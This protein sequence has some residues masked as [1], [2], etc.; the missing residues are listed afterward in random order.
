MSARAAELAGLLDRAPPGIG[1]LSLD[2]FD[3]LVWRNVQA[4]IDIFADLPIPGGGIWSRTQA[5]ILARRHALAAEGRHEV[6]LREIYRNLHPFAADGEIDAAI[7]RELEAEARHCYA[8]AP[9]VELIRDAQRRGLEVIV[10]SDTYLDADQLRALIASA[11]G[12][13]IAAMVGRIFCSSAY[14]VPKSLG[15]FERILPELPVPA[16]AILH[17]GDNKAADQDAP[18]R[19]GINAVHFI[20]FDAAAEQRLRMEAAAATMLQPRVRRTSPAFQP[21]RPMVSL[22]DHDDRTWA[23]GHNVLGPILHGFCRWLGDEIDADSARLGRA[24]KPLFL[25]RDGHLPHR[26]FEALGGAA[27]AVEISRFTARRAGFLRAQ[28]IRDYLCVQEDSVTAE[29]M[30]GQLGIPRHERDR[31]VR[32]GRAA[33]I[34][35]MLQPKALGRTR[36]RAEAFADRLFGHL[37]AAGVERGDAVMLIDLGY[38]GTAQDVL[39]PVL[40]ARYGLDVSGRYLLLREEQQT[41]L[42]KKGYLDHRHY[43]MGALHALSGPVALIEQLCTVPQGSVV[44]YGPKGEAIRRG[45]DLKA[46]QNN[47]RDRIQDG[48]LAFANTAGRGVSRPAASDDARSRRDAAAACLARLLF[49][50]SA[51]EVEI[52]SAF[53]HDVNLGTSET[54]RL[55]DTDEAAD[56]LRRRGLFYLSGNKRLHLPGELQPQGLPLN[57]AL[58]SAVRFGLELRATDFEAGGLTLPVIVAD[59][60]SQTLIEV[61]AHRT[62]DGYYLATIPVGGGDYAVG[63][64]FGVLCDWLQI[65][66]AAFYP[67]RRF[68][69]R[70]GEDK[71]TPIPAPALFEGMNEEGEG[72]FRCSADALM[73]APPL[74]QTAREP[75]LLAITFR[76]IVRRSADALRKAA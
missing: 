61:E 25:L 51:D 65:E 38:N 64:Q 3:T 22:A 45:G 66:E 5:E 54:V 29:V 75:H 42:D 21:H 72:L 50:P 15:L 11:A 14:G 12:D 4:P 52:F 1:M 35:T 30:A 43:D 39:E 16:S 2:C 9:V 7:A 41:G 31:I 18:G 36:E 8:F 53:E 19:I 34:R 23:L 70:P 59:D 44:D 73:L 56:G 74:P 33:F 46:T 47:I 27:A 55:L 32:D 49:M 10:V 63:V 68:T 26:V 62:H 17:V 48:C 20:Q 57:L 71:A 6:T 67:V 60:R 69:P 24:V 76:P 37:E 58:F 40:R 28:A 13:E